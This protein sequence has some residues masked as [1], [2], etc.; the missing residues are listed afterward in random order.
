MIVPTSW[1]VLASFAVAP[2]AAPPAIDPPPQASSRA[3][4]DLDSVADAIAA[5]LDARRRGSGLDVAR[6]RLTALLGAHAAEH[7]ELLARPGD[8]RRALRLAQD[9]DDERRRTGK[10]VVETFA[11][12]NAGA[13]EF[14]FVFRLPSS[15]DPAERKWPLILAVHDVGQDPAQHLRENWTDRELLDGAIF[16]VPQMPAGQASWDQVAVQGE[17]GGLCHLLTAL[18]LAS[19]RF[20]VDPD[21]VYVAGRGKSVP[22]VVAAGNYGPQLFAGVIGRAGDVADLALQGPENFS[23]LPTYFVGGGAGTAA[24]KVAVDAAGFGNC[25]LTTDTS[26]KALWQWIDEHPRNSHPT[27]VSIQVGT[28]YPTR[29]YW[30]RIAPTAPDARALADID[31]AKN[32]IRIESRSVS[33][34]TL[35]LDDE[36]VDLDQPVRVLRAGAGALEFTPRRSPW[37]MLELLHDGTSDAR[38]IYVAEVVLDATG[39]DSVTST[40]DPEARPALESELAKTDDDPA[41]LWELFLRKQA[42]EAR[43]GES[44]GAAHV[45]RRLLRVAPNHAQA[46]G[47]AGHLRAPEQLGNQWFTSQAAHDRFWQRQDRDTAHSKGWVEVN[48]FWMHPADRALVG[49]GLVKDLNT[50]EWLSADDR[51]R[52]DAGWARQDL[53]WIPPDAAS[54]VDAGE[55]LVAGEWLTLEQANRR[56]S[57]VDSRWRIPSP[58]VVVHGTADRAT[59]LRAQSEMIAALSALQRV[60][61]IEPQLPLEALVL[62]DEEQY[63]TFAFGAPDGRRA[64]AHAGRMHVVHTA[65]FAESWFESA[66]A[67]AQATSGLA[68]GSVDTTGDAGL[69]FEGMG[70]CYWDP[71]IPHGDSYGRHAARLAIGLSWVEAIDP[72]PKAVRDALRTLSRGSKIPDHYAAYQAEKLLP[73]WLRWGAAVYAERYFRDPTVGPDGD[74]WWARAWSLQNLAERGGL[75]PLSEVLEFELDPGDPGDRGDPG[76]GLRWLL[77]AGVLVAFLVDGECPP[78]AK[79]H[80]AFVD[81]LLKG[82]LHPKNV[83][84]LNDALVANEDALRAWMRAVAGE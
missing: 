46:R 68:T 75:R 24:W 70:V 54:R 13:S 63:D 50:G 28:P 84:A 38:C 14:Q 65:H 51:R 69:R 35:Y 29:A 66:G 10:I 64:P 16:V 19:E 53:T 73:A 12:G 15:Y 37:L 5:C 32:T 7:G 3:D 33:S 74:A 61:G 47:V 82:R 44:A 11:L 23:N 56:R 77:E 45:W 20:A 27:R 76:E 1:L 43:S 4:A 80:A 58:E 30:L 57:R 42:D 59:L 40:T 49:K 31:R 36:L 22:T 67:S 18:R 72:S 62:R 55:W 39:A 79:V 41:R 60:F 17:P 2:I 6:K 78:V 25:T 34:V 48:G 21:R 71:A 26:G 8:L 9:F 81:A 52:I 83:A